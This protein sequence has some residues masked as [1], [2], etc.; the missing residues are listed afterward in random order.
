M[1][2]RDNK[3]ETIKNK[4]IRWQNEINSGRHDGWVTEYFK[5]KLERIKRSLYS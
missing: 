3:R 5:Q 1:K 2:N 4:I